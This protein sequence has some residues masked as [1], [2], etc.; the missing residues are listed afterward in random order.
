MKLAG[1][2]L[3]WKKSS[4][5][6]PVAGIPI[7]AFTGINGAGKTLLAV[8]A[9]IADMLAGRTVYSTV[10]IAYTAPDG[11]LYESIPLVDLHQLVKLRDCTVLLD[12]IAVMFSSTTSTS[13]LPG[14]VEVF[15]QTAR[16][17]RV[18]VYWTAPDWMRSQTLVRGAT[19]ACVNVVPLVRRPS[20]SFWPKPVLL[21]VGVGDTT[22]GKKD[23]TPSVVRRRRVL[24]PQRLQS[25]GAYDS[26]APTPLL[27]VRSGRGICID[28]LGSITVPRHSEA[29]HRELGLEWKG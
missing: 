24:V 27:G 29:R 1:V 3:S 15:F 7:A 5:Y 2:E 18:T 20:D 21:G 8:Q 26:E 13:S 12:D 23:A 17:S 28:C 4:V 10:P 14:E 11:T 9:C 22:T 25:W 6:N 16:H 19:Q